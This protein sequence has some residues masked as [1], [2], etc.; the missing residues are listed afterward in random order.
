MRIQRLLLPALAVLLAVP[1]FAQ[2]FTASIRG[3]VTDQSAAVISGAQVTI[4]NEET[5]LTRKIKTNAAGSYSVADLPVGTYTVEVEA[6]GFTNA[7]RSKVELTVA[8]VRDV[9]VQMQTGG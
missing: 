2:R 1:V 8:Q 4:K 5:G 9:D 7:V 3:T 6:A